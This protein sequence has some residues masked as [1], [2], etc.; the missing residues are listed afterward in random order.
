MTARKKKGI[1]LV[2]TGAVSCVVGVVLIAV[3]STPTYV[4]TGILVVTAVC[5][6][7]GLYFVA[8]DTTVS[9]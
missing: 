9:E 1:G 4:T 8:P 2:I 6:T 5:N 7:L 3:T